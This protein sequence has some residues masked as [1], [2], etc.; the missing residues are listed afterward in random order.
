M[1]LALAAGGPDIAGQDRERPVLRPEEAAQARELS[2]TL[3]EL[4]VAAGEESSARLHEYAGHV[5]T[6]RDAYLL[7]VRAARSGRP[8]GDAP[9]RALEKALQVWL[10]IK[11]DLL[12]V[13]DAAL[14]AAI[15]SHTEAVQAFVRTLDAALKEGDVPAIPA[16]TGLGAGGSRWNVPDDGSLRDVYQ[17]ASGGDSIELTGNVAHA[18]L[19]RQGKNNGTPLRI[20]GPATIRMNPTGGSDT[21]HFGR[22]GFTTLLNL[23]IEPDDRAAVM[24][25]TDT[26]YRSI[27]FLDCKIGLASGRGWNAET[28]TGFRGKWGVLSYELDDFRFVGGEVV[29]IG[30][31]HCFY[32][33]NPSAESAEQTAILIQ[34]ATLR[35]ARRTAVQVVARG[36]EGRPGQGNVII[37][38]CQIEDV[39]L[40]D[41]G[42][43]SAL[44][45]RGNLNGTVYVKD[46]SV[47]LGANPRLHPRVGRNITG[48]LVMDVG[49]GARRGTKALIVENCDFQVGPHFVGTGSARRNNVDVSQVRHFELTGTRIYNHP[50]SAAA[51]SI[52]A[53][54]IDRIVLDS[55]NEVVGDCVLIGIGRFPDPDRKGLGY[56]AMLEAVE[57]AREGDDEVRRA[58]AEKVEIR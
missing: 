4:W 58:T 3:V 36:H 43:G 31:E 20:Q 9:S 28:N 27:H 37:D 8:A 30:K 18:L 32:H 47:R 41:G 29:G 21:L 7:A 57:A 49:T 55:G 38:G 54:S 10:P 25:N 5:L 51:L 15:T 45:F 12:R 26:R 13:E 19:E 1:L 16:A 6:V 33:H 22:A 44:T 40:E 17:K 23:T 35:W 48:A 50:G 14:A 42:G 56:R 24:F 52:D 39:C 46:T 11:E 53:R 34:N 2:I